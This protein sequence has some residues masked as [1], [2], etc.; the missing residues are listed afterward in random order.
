MC[1]LT[2]C[3]QGSSACLHGV[4][5][6]ISLNAFLNA[7]SYSLYSLVCISIRNTEFGLYH[8]SPLL[9]H[10]KRFAVWEEK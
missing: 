4:G 2:H 9:C 10:I 5:P 3:V 7:H 8:L 1:N 6:L